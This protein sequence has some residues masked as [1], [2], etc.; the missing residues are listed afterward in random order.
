MAETTLHAT[1]R[2]RL[3]EE[4]DRLHDQL[5][6]MGVGP[7]GKLDFDDGFADSG[8]VTAERGEVEALGGT[9]LDTLREI[10]DAL[11][12]F[13]DGTYGLC[14]SCGNQIAEARLEAMPAARLCINC[15]SRRR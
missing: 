2:D 5:R 14:E 3:Q 11:H 1:L 9:L 15:A 4:R 13:D 6:Q 10:E 7:G 8:Q 12:K